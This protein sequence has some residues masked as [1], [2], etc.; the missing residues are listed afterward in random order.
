LGDVIVAEGLSKLYPGGAGLRRLDLRVEEGEVF[1][2]LGANG[3]GKTTTIRLLL[4]LIRPTGGRATVMG[5]DCRH[6]S[7]EVRRRIGYLPGDLRLWP[8]LSGLETAH[9]VAGLRDHAVRE[10]HLQQL[11]HTLDLD[12]HHRVGTYSK[13]NRQKLGILLALLAEPPVLVLD[14]PTSGLDPILQRTV[15]DLLHRAREQGSTVFFSS[16]VMS[17][18][19]EVCDRVGI[20]RQGELVTAQPVAALRDRSVRHVHVSFAGEAPPPA[21]LALPGVRELSRE[22]T[23]VELEVVGEMDRLVKALAPFHVLD[24]RTEQ[25]TLDEVLLEYYRA[26]PV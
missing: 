7:H 26:A 16:H 5:F 10:V 17:E 2:F 19:E 3:A 4:D 18:V 8:N 21:T 13:G 22:R 12:L 23:A 6:Q 14:E 20:L 11:A 25:P 1:G 15:W 24:V 9:L